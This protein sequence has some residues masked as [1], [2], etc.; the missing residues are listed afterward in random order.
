MAEEH[1]S[2]HVPDFYI[3][4]GGSLPQ[5]AAVC[6]GKTTL[7][8]NARQFGT[9]LGR[10][11]VR[12]RNAGDALKEIAGETQEATAACLST[13]AN[14]TKQAGARVSDVAGNLANQVTHKTRE[15]SKAATSSADELRHAALCRLQ[16]A[17]LQ[18]RIAYRRTRLRT[19]EAVREYPVQ[20]V[21][22]AGVMGFL[23]GVGLRL[24]RA[25][26]ES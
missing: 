23:L 22:A 13:L 11:V 7:E 15:W 24:W 1:R 12:L 16:D 10:A 5:E 21:F 20:V 2:T 9:T 4:P 3:D 18:T 26:H 17:R 25:N 19:H 14:Q 8:Q 6:N